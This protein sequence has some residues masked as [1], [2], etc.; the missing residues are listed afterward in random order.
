MA[1]ES[2]NPYSEARCMVPSQYSRGEVLRDRLDGNFLLL[3][4]D[5]GPFREDPVQRDAR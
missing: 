1:G 4:D 2:G 5:H 3:T